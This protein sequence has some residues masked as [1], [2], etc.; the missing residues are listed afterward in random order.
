M[1]QAID[2]LDAAGLATVS[3]LAACALVA[4]VNV[5]RIEQ[6]LKDAEAELRRIVEEA[7]PVAMFELGLTGLTLED[8]STLKI[9]ESVHAAI[10]KANEAEAFD[11]LRKH[12]LGDVI[13]NDITASFGKDED[14]KAQALVVSLSKL[15]YVYKR[16]ESVHPGTLKALAR[17]KIVAGDPLPED[18]FGVHTINRAV[19][20]RT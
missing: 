19:I 15:G 14:A 1:N 10:T 3:R 5:E 16:R 12:E 13:K 6:E 7:L 11:W 18:L 9:E 4:Q 2:I 17:E 20:K 8:G